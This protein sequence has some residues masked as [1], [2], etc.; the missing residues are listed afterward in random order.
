MWSSGWLVP[1]P[2]V[3]AFRVAALPSLYGGELTVG[4]DGVTRDVFSF[5]A[6]QYVYAVVYANYNCNRPA[7]AQASQTTHASSPTK[8]SLVDIVLTQTR[9]S[10][11]STRLQ[12]NVTKF[13]RGL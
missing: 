4:T 6:T 9:K 5:G 1:T 8:A 11:S 13:G 10:M 2:H 7:G 12:C 3:G